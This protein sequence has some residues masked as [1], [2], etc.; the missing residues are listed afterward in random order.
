M[1]QKCV[2]KNPARHVIILNWSEDTV[3]LIRHLSNF[4]PAGTEITFVRQKVIPN[5]PEKLGSV[6]FRQVRT[7][8]SGNAAGSFWYQ[9]HSTERMA[10][11]N[12]IVSINECWC[13]FSAA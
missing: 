4:S 1:A 6:R 8:C 2:V 3:D 7:L 9:S 13:W 11:A 12:S 5:L 10:G